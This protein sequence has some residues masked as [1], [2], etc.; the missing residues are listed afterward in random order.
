M[1]KIAILV[2]MFASS[3][4]QAQVHNPSLPPGWTTNGAVDSTQVVTAPGTLAAGAST[5]TSIGSSGVT[6]PDSSIQATA[7]GSD[8]VLL[9]QVR[10]V[11]GGR[12]YNK[13][14]TVSSTISAA[15]AAITDNGYSKRYLILVPSGTYNEEFTCKSYVD[16]AAADNAT[17]KVQSSSGTTDTIKCG[18]FESM[19]SGFEV[20][21]TFNTGDAGNF[22]YPIHLDGGGDN[23]V[24]APVVTTTILNKMTLKAL[25]TATKSGVGIGFNNVQRFYIVDSNIS[26]TTIDGCFAHNVIN[27][28]NPSEIY[29]LN[30]TCAGA[31]YGFEF[32][33]AGSAKTDLVSIIGGAYTG[34]TAGIATNNALGG[35]AEMVI[36]VDSSTT[37]NS[38]S[39]VSGQVKTGLRVV[40]IPSAGVGYQYTGNTCSDPLGLC[41]GLRGALQSLRSDKRVYLSNTDG[42]IGYFDGSSFVPTVAVFTFY[43][44]SGAKT[45]AL[46]IASGRYLRLSANGQPALDLDSNSTANFYGSVNGVGGFLVNGVAG[47]DKVCS[48][49]ITAVTVSKGIITAITCP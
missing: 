45:S 18:G 37:A 25:G 36:H 27:E 40:P 26:S 42:N 46:S 20:D 6:F 34:G 2:L 39:F 9:A 11:I 13:I 33:N 3:L 7:A 38:T 1:K 4:A 32:Q 49:A 47:T 24:P 10:S 15:L 31:T 19:L 29:L 35:A 48:T 16:I 23:L 21:H 22:Q 12:R 28:A 5:P 8:P 43:F 41:L 44:D 14:V 30:T 17:V